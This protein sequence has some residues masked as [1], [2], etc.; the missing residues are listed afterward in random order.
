MLKLEDLA[1]LRSFVN[2]GDTVVKLE[3]LMSLN[4]IFKHCLV[5]ELELFEIKLR[6]KIEAFH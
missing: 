5:L 1:Q 4:Y 2:I 6:V 3:P